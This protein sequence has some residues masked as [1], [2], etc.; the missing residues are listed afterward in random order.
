MIYIFVAYVKNYLNQKS[1][2][3]PETL[4]MTCLRLWYGHSFGGNAELMKYMIKNV[5]ISK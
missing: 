5:I 1:W 2:L 4:V 3:K